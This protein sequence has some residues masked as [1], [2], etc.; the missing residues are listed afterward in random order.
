MARGLLYT[1]VADLSNVDPEYPCHEHVDDLSHVL[2]AE[3][4][5]DFK[6]KLLQAGRIVGSEVNR[7]KL[8]LSTKSKIIPDNSLT[9]VVARTLTNEGIP[10]D[11]AKKA[12]DVGVEM[13]GAHGRAAS[14]L[15][16]RIHDKVA[17]RASRAK[18]L[19][20]INPTATKFVM[21]GVHPTQSYGH[22]AM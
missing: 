6:N 8:K 13:S 3:T 5:F 14:T 7:L 21:S 4:E 18:S 9:H 16:S 17:P 22:Q 10:L 20:S 11:V 12:D 15:N 2:V 19:V 1:L